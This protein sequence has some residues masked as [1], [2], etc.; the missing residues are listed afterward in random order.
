M[1]LELLDARRRFA[2]VPGFAE[3]LKPHADKLTGEDMAKAIAA[4]KLYHR[5]RG[6][7]YTASVL[8]TVIQRCE[9]TV[10]AEAAQGLL[11]AA[12]GNGKSPGEPLAFFL[13]KD[14]ALARYEYPPKP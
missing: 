7:K 13:D 14:K 5:L 8:K 6:R 12:K 3:K 4:G 10:Y 1:G 2:H 9:G 11:D